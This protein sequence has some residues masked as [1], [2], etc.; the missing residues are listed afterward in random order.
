MLFGGLVTR[1]SKKNEFDRYPNTPWIKLGMRQGQ[2]FTPTVSINTLLINRLLFLSYFFF[3]RF[4]I[5][6]KDNVGYIKYYMAIISGPSC[7]IN[8]LTSMITDHCPHHLVMISL[9]TF[10]VYMW[11]KKGFLKKKIQ[12]QKQTKIQ[13]IVTKYIIAIGTRWRLFAIAYWQLK[14]NFFIYSKTNKPTHLKLESKSK[15]KALKTCM[16]KKKTLK[17]LI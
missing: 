6:H 9:Y 7:Q 17:K 15:V 13:K 14:S 16:H 1:G 12:R 3:V 5:C 2:K 8:L 4:E 11:S 10:I